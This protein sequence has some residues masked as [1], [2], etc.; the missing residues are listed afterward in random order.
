MKFLLLVSAVLAVSL[1]VCAQDNNQKPPRAREYPPL[2]RQ[3]DDHDQ[4]KYDRGIYYGGRGPT[5]VSKS[6]GLQPCGIFRKDGKKYRYVAGEV[7]LDVWKGKGK[8]YSEDDLKRIR[9]EHAAAKILPQ[10]FS[11]NDL[12]NLQAA[13]DDWYHQQVPPG[14]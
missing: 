6:Y 10:H 7:P 4:W 13:C 3:N 11:K 12:T 1:S 5:S 14:P 8:P 9:D 2:H